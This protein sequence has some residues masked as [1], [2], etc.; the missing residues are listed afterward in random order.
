M[1]CLV[2]LL[3]LFMPRLAIVLVFLF[4]D[5]LARAYE[6]TIW[7]VLGFFFAPLTTLAYAFAINQNGSVSGLYLVV[8]VFAVLIDLGILGGNASH[9]RS[10]RVVVVQR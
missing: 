8:V 2:G 1:P 7:P 6:T 3:A 4:S 5:Y 9:G 10:K